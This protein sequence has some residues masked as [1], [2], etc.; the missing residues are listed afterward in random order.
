MATIAKSPTERSPYPTSP[1]A[2]QPSPRGDAITGDRYWSKD[3]AER[4]WDHIWKRVW[5]VGGRTSQL[6]EPGDF[7]THEFKTESVI[8]VKQDDGT[9]RAFFNVCMHRG[10]RL[11]QAP[12]GFV[13]GRFTCPYHGWKWGIDGAL[14]DVQDPEDFEVNPCGRLRLKELPCDTWGGFIWFSFDPQ[15]K[16]LR[17]F[18]SPIPDLLGNRDLDNWTRVVWRQ[19]RVNTNW[20]FASDN[21]NE[22][23]HIPAVHPQFMPMIDDHYSTTVFEIYPNGHNR[24]IEKFQPS[25]RYPDAEQM[26]PLWAQVLSEW[27]IDPQAYADRAQEARI[28]LQQAR[29]QLGPARGHAHFSQLSDWELTDQFHHT[30]F[31]NVTLTGTPEG[32]HFFRTQPL[33][34]DP[35][36]STFDYWYLVPKIEGADEVATLYGMR[37]YEEAEFEDGDFA[38]YEATIAQGD[39]LAQDLS[40]AVTQ[41]KGLRSMAFESAYL[42]KQEARVARFHEVINDYLEGRR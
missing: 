39:F 25:S 22:A 3:F 11:L 23:Y 27:D 31:P 36:W 17:E 41:Q 35:N 5:H 37:P 33:G 26:K 28:A 40:L 30:L 12:E 9:I 18:L 21:F 16:P 8:L 19:L 34:D 42:S 2:A 7:V 10:N 29:R 1:D 32:L 38:E 20:K 6:E 4:E 13:P 24:M 14:K 15:A